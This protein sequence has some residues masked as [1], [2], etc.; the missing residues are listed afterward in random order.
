L[1]M[2]FSQ[3]SCC[4]IQCSR[5]GC[6]TAQ[7][8]QCCPR[9]THSWFV[10]QC[11][12]WISYSPQSSLWR[13]R[14]Y[15][16]MQRLCC[17]CPAQCLCG[18][19]TIYPMTSMTSIGRYMQRWLYILCSKLLTTTCLAWERGGRNQGPCR[20][21]TSHEEPPILY[22]CYACKRCQCCKTY[23]VHSSKRTTV[24]SH[25]WCQMSHGGTLGRGRNGTEIGGRRK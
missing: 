11:F 21:R 24:C 12:E 10:C 6:G 25:G 4:T 3:K 19:N 13:L 14:N 9:N 18:E 22:Q 2:A 15:S 16:C 1:R 17:T 8:Q 20:N 23:V 5:E 7:G